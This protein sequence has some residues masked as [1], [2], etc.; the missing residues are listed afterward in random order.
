MREIVERSPPA[1]EQPSTAPARDRLY[2][3]LSSQNHA[4][5]L[6][7]NGAPLAEALEVIV[8]T[9]EMIS[10]EDILGSILLLGADGRLR[11]GAAS[12]LP[13]AYVRAVDGAAIGPSAGACGT[14]AH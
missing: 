2:R 5:D 8:R 13:P 9:G 1:A 4:L 6:A 11:H 7:L 14:A 3:V 12:S 10:D